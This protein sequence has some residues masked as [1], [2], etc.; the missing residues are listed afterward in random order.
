MTLSG[1]MSV[2]MAVLRMPHPKVLRLILKENYSSCAQC[3]KFPFKRARI[4]EGENDSYQKQQRSWCFLAV[5]LFLNVAIVPIDQSVNSGCYRSKIGQD[6]HSEMQVCCGYVLP[7]FVAT[8]LLVFRH[9][10]L[11][12]L[13]NEA[14]R[15]SENEQRVLVAIINPHLYSHDVSATDQRP[16]SRRSLL[17]SQQKKVSRN[18]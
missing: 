11:E 6:K 12:S 2:L 3:L 18:E 1:R 13:G 16:E 10:H 4:Y 17:I 5:F 15:N 14:S 8:L 7:K 9:W